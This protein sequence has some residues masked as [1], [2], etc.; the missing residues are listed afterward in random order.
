MSAD[1]AAFDKQHEQAQESIDALVAELQDTLARL[2]QEQQQAGQLSERLQ[3]ATKEGA[4][5]EKKV[6]AHNSLW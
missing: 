4:D 6:G 2:E 3:Q 1:K 5:K